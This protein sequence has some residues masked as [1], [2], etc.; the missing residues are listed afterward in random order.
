MKDMKIIGENLQNN[1]IILEIGNIEF[2]EMR[3]YITGEVAHKLSEQIIREHGEKLVKSVL[4]NRSEIV[5][6]TGELLVQEALNKL[7]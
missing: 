2:R 7:K 6:K 4:D 1:S 3:G 5:K